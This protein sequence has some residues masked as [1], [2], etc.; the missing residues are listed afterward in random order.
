VLM[1]EHRAIIGLLDGWE[2][3]ARKLDSGGRFSDAAIVRELRSDLQL[4]YENLDQQDY[5][6]IGSR[7]AHVR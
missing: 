5:D 6:G 3:K 2:K 4:S 1:R 7:A